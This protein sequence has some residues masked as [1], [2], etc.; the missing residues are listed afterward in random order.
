M[1]IPKISLHKSNI[2]KQYRPF[3]GQPPADWIYDRNNRDAKAASK[4]SV[5]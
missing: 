2:E 3:L 1:T 4:S 5:K